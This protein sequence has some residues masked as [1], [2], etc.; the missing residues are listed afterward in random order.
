LKLKGNQRCI[1][2]QL[3]SGML[4]IRYKIMIAE[5]DPVVGVK[6]EHWCEKL[7]HIAERVRFAPDVLNR[8]IDFEPDILILDLEFHGELVGI[9]IAREIRKRGFNT[10]IVIV[11]SH[12]IE[13]YEDEVLEI[14]YCFMQYKEITEAQLRATIKMVEKRCFPAYRIPL[15]KLI[16]KVKDIAYIKADEKKSEVFYRDGNSE[17]IGKPLGDLVGV[18]PTHIQIV[19]VHKSFIAN[20]H[21]ASTIT[22]SEVKIELLD[23]GECKVPIGRTYQSELKKKLLQM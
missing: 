2:Q 8:F 9:D 23:G 17:V 4:R 10:P 22:A 21:Y 7:R 6:L 20:L 16:L 19:R 13:R 18:I 15:D 14:A 12:E 11:T 1:K 5:D 3:S